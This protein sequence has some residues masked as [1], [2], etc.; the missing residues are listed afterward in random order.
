MSWHED[1]PESFTPQAVPKGDAELIDSLSQLPG[2]A[3]VMFGNPYCL[4]QFDGWKKY[5]SVLLAYQ[6]MWAAQTAAAEAVFGSIAPKGKLPVTLGGEFEKGEGLT[7]KPIGRLAFGFYPQGGIS[8]GAMCTVDSLLADIPATGS[9]PGGRLI[10][11]RGGR[12]VI[13]RSFGTTMYGDSLSRP[14]TP[15]RCTIWLR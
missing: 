1:N 15:G 9:A 14:V 12:M 10:V 11:A 13:D 4:L 8:A 2:A 5:G 6:N 3:F 7:F